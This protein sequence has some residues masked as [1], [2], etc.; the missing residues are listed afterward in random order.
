MMASQEKSI[1][2]ADSSFTEIAVWWDRAVGG[3]YLS[4]ATVPESAINRGGMVALLPAVKVYTAIQALQN[5]YNAAEHGES[6]QVAAHAWDQCHATVLQ[7]L[8]P[9]T[10]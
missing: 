1:H 8:H 3:F 4:K 2:N 10:L 9:P 6:W 7:T 5:P